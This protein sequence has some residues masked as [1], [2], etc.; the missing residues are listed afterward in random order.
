MISGVVGGGNEIVPLRVHI[1]AVGADDD[2][3]ADES[4]STSGRTPASQ[5][6]QTP[7]RGATNLVL[8]LTTAM[9]ISSVSP[10]RAR[11]EAMEKARG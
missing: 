3:L 6:E 10:C 11:A 5:L 8:Y 2:D 4:A 9:R 1:N 7:R